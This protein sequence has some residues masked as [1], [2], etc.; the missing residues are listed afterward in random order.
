M[1]SVS[2]YKVRV[3]VRTAGNVRDGSILSGRIIEEHLGDGD[4]DFFSSPFSAM[5]SP[6]RLSFAPTCEY[7]INILFL[8]LVMSQCSLLLILSLTLFASHRV[9][10]VIA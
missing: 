5:P 8:E 1:I 10:V 4:V 7:L 2:R 3:L 9:P 6:I